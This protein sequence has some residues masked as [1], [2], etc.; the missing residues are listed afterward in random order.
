MG[1]P[2]KT[3]EEILVQMLENHEFEI[4]P[5]HTPPSEYESVEKAQSEIYQLMLSLIPDEKV[6]TE[7]IPLNQAERGFN[8]AIQDVKRGLSEHFNGEDKS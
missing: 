4:T 7:K 5:V 8:I 3:V 2:L 6:G 1:K